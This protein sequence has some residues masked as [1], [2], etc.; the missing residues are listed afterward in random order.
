[1]SH[2]RPVAQCVL[3]Q[4]RKE[5]AFAQSDTVF[6]DESATAWQRDAWGE[7]LFPL[8]GLEPEEGGSNKG[9]ACGEPDLE[10]V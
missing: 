2:E 8:V 6:C 9:V 7:C 5:C 3:S 10:E 4:P 1:M